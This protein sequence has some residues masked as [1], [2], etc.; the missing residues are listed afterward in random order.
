LLS[1]R[2]SIRHLSLVLEAMHEAAGFTRNVRLM[3]EHVRS[4]LALQISRSLQ[5][6]DGFI[7]VIPLSPQ[8]ERELNEAIVV[9]GD[10][11]TF[12]LAPSRTQE[13]VQAV[14]TKLASA[15]ARGSWPAILTSVEVR[16]F[17]RTM[18]ERVNPTIAVISHAEIHQRSKLRT[19][20]QL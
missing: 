14:R 18:V 13:F 4:R 8:W 9:D 11:R 16:P 7:A 2:I 5:G 17:V 19:V 15:S 10:Q 6:E 20:D 3:T 12:V 1:E